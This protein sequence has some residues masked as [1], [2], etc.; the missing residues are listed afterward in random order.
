VS[1]NQ[2][3]EREER[4]RNPVSAEAPEYPRPY[5]DRS[6]GIIPLILWSLLLLSG[7]LAVFLTGP[8][9]AP[10]FDT[11]TAFIC[12]PIPALYGS[13]RRPA[14]TLVYTCRSDANVVYQRGSPLTGAK[15]R[16]WED[17]RKAGGLVKI[18]RHANPSRYGN[19]IFQTTCDGHIYSDYKS[20]A[21]SYNEIHET[22][23]I[24]ALGVVTLSI[25]RL[26]LRVLRR[27]RH[28]PKII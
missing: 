6:M 20:Q 2:P 15:A 7:I 23:L 11:L 3:D 27:F 13:S 19:F 12:D 17:C 28:R 18:W 1:L 10:A 8:H 21:L 26:A 25:T 4:F 16:A 5:H 9:E 22:G 24:I 14:P